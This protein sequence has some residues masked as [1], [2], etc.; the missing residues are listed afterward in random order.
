MFFSVFFCFLF[1]F[2]GVFKC[3]CVFCFVLLVCFLKNC[4]FALCFCTMCSV[5]LLGDKENLPIYIYICSI[6]SPASVSVFIRPLWWGSVLWLELKALQKAQTPASPFIS[7]SQALQVRQ[8][9]K[10][11]SSLFQLNQFD[12]CYLLWL[13]MTSD[14]S[15]WRLDVTQLWDKIEKD[16]FSN[17]HRLPHGDWKHGGE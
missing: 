8:Q 10:R 9:P 6:M 4:C 2:Y 13:V 12:W 16:I 5:C 7:E 3:W 1:C 14:F 17:T 15:A 11:H